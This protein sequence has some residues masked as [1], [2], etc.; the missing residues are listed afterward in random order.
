MTNK[1]SRRKFI[2]RVFGSLFT[3]IA[4]G[5]GGFFYARDIEPKLLE[6]NQHTIKHPSIPKSFHNIKIVQFSDI[7]L[8]FHYDLTQLKKLINKINEFEPEIIIFTGDLMDEPNKY[9]RTEMVAPLLSEL[10]ASIGKYSIYGNHDHGGYG[11]DIY[12]TIMNEAGFD[13]L[14]NE[15]RIIK[16]E[17]EKI[18][19][20]GIDDAM[21]G[22]PDIKAAVADIPN[23]SYHIFLSHAPD[24]ADG[25]SSFNVNLQLSGHSH[26]GQIQV[27]FIG[28][29]VKPPYGERYYE[30]FYEIGQTDPLLLYVNRGIGTT[31]LPFRFL[32]RPELSVFTLQSEQQ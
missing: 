6:I 22:R 5:A 26:G 1:V 14:L 27:P 16:N 20:S 19:L 17:D 2:K 10:K 31:R 8:G 18:Y 11:S 4:A 29:L 23:D 21:L 3:A 32:C 25:A 28:A 24:L 9:N 7:H 15:S 30:G 12:K 13:L